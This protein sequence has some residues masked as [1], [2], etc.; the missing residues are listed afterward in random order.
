[1]HVGE[2][3]SY[4]FA[5][6]GTFRLE[7]N[8]FA[9]EVTDQ[10]TVEQICCIYVF[11]LGGEIVRVGC[12]QAPLKKRLRSWHRDLTRD[13]QPSDN[14]MPSYAKQWFDALTDRGSGTIYARP[15]TKVVTP[16][17]EITTHLDEER[18]LIA[19]YRPRFNL[20]HR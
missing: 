18:V 16:L 17:G 20:S 4:G 6:V 1:M 19:R 15:A 13:F 10:Q 5:P 11:V 12:S 7:N 3:A 14:P 9:I 8:T 2:L